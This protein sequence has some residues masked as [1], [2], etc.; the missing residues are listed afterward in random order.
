[1][2]E[3]ISLS[4]QGIWA[5][6]MRSFLT[7]LGI[8]IGIASIITIVAT[9]K[10]TNEQIKE[11]LIGAGNNVVDVELRQDNTRYDAQS[12]GIPD[13]VSMITEKTRR[14]LEKLDGVKEVSLYRYR[15]YSYSDNIFYLNTQYS[16]PVY[17]IDTHYF[18]VNNYEITLG[19][20]FTQH[21]NDIYHK[22]CI[23]D[24]VA[25]STVFGGENPVG[26]ILEINRE[27]F[28]VIAVVTSK[29]SSDNLI[30]TV[31][32]YYTYSGSLSGAVFIP[33]AAWTIVYSYDEPQMAS[34][35]A[36]STDSMTKAGKNVADALTA[37]QIRSGNKFTYRANN[38][39]ERAGQMQSLSNRTNQQLLWIAGIS[40]LVGGIGVM[41][42]MLVSVTER[43]KEIGLKKAIGA[44]KRVIRAQFLTEAAVLTSIGGIIG[45]ASG[46]GFSGVFSRIMGTPSSI[47]IPACV[48][49][50]VFS[51]GIGI[52]FGLL[53]AV[54]ASNLNP[55]VAL[56]S[57]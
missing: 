55:I 39:L 5:H 25:A 45:V 41:N 12:M 6:K 35:K 19:R 4:F 46:I 11:D 7:M 57:E 50:V 54:R 42:I 29:N 26:K 10:G 15:E 38:L 53:P 32:D 13:Q 30:K 8:I 18:S 48:V 24:S 43:T 22:V 40:L 31:E 51:M 47:S 3:N 52:I 36:D 28:V 20:P 44:K 49:S 21:D 34:V 17:G 27:P 56:R 2:I 1:M 37:S 16:G 9:I 23:V 14:A 33:E